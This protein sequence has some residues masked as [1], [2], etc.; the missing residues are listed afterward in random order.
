MD[1]GCIFTVFLF[2]FILFFDDCAVDRS[3]ALLLL[4][5][6]FVCLFYFRCAV[7]MCHLLCSRTIPGLEVI[8]LF[9]CSTAEHEIFFVNKYENANNSWHFHIY[10]MHQRNFHAQ[11]RLAR[12][13]LH[14]LIN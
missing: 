10:Y 9:S 13:N 2:L 3:N 5:F 14:L 7:A 12:K 6:H 11:Q 8:K 1:Q 4:W